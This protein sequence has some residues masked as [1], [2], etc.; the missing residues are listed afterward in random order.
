M[1]RTFGL[2]LTLTFTSFVHAEADWRCQCYADRNSG[3]PVQSAVH[4]PR[5]NALTLEQAEQRA[6][7]LCQMSDEFRSGSERSTVATCVAP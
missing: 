4:V 2:V 5:S 3:E 7:Q 6:L 1:N